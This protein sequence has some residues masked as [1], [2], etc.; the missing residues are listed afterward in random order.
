MAGIGE[1]TISILAA[2]LWA[3]FSISPLGGLY[4][5]IKAHK[6][7]IQKVRNKTLQAG[8]DMLHYIETNDGWRLP[9]V[10]Y[11]P[12]SKNPKRNHP[13][14]LLH[15]LSG[16]RLGFDLPPHGPSLA[17]TLSAAGFDVWVLEMRGSN[18]SFHPDFLNHPE[19][20]QWVFADYVDEDFSRAVEFLLQFTGAKAVHCIGH[21]MG[22]IL[23][24]AYASLSPAHTA[25]IKSNTLLA[26]S[27]T[28]QGS[29]SRFEKLVPFYHFA[30]VWPILEE[31][32]IPNGFITQAQDLI[33]GFVGA[34]MPDGSS[35]CETPSNVDLA[36]WRK[37]H[38]FGFHTVPAKLIQSLYTATAKPRG[39][40]H[41][42]RVAY[43]DLMQNMVEDGGKVPNTLLFGGNQDT[44]CPIAAVQRT[45]DRLNEIQPGAARTM[46]F[47]RPHGH[48]ADYGHCD[49]LIGK[50]VDYEVFPAII[51]FLAE[52][53]VPE[54]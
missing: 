32:Y 1:R 44:Q 10:R 30:K 18:L 27:L 6:L 22:G 26:S 37:L 2:F 29:G 8:V 15:G 7:N 21:S 16:N 11:I 42:N 40:C 23:C 39:L 38:R 13:V 52:N 47:G 36:A 4:Y 14:L 33:M 28:Y 19:V 50:R 53:D 17:R 54:S 49:F 46:W 35:S 34:L 51:N 31:Y 45:A 25:R 9:L 20:Q 12:S 24:T 43:L 41:R 3:L 5:L 48:V